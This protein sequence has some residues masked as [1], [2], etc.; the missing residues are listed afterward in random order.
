MYQIIMKDGGLTGE[1]SE[2]KSPSLVAKAIMRV[3][4]QKTGIKNKEIRFK[5][6][7]N[8][9]E[10]T[11]KARIIELERPTNINIGNKK[12]LKKYSIFVE[13]I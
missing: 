6:L 4:Y 8:G 2:K 10:Y 11:Y 7:K 5:N 12:F 3:L 1:Y 13:R 9:K